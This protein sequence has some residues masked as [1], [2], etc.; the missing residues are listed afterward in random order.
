M[1]IQYVTVYASVNRDRYAYLWVNQSL[2]HCH[3][4]IINNANVYWIWF[5]KGVKVLRI[6]EYRNQLTNESGVSFHSSIQFENLQY[7]S[8]KFTL[9]S[10]DP[11]FDLLCAIT[12]RLSTLIMHQPYRHKYHV[13][14]KISNVSKFNKR[15]R[16]FYSY[17]M[18][19]T[20]FSL[21]FK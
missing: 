7:K 10:I 17:F 1:L 8:N 6:R 11:D 12:S 18:N 15:V 13:S 14:K 21:S 9:K 19:L 5:L 3:D 20:D 2:I 4:K 16:Y